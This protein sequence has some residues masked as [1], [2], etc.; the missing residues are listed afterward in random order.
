MDSATSHIAAINQPN[1]SAEPEP[2]LILQQ[3][4]SYATDD[5][6][7]LG[8]QISSEA[9]GSALEID[10]LPPGTTLSSG[11][12]VGQGGWRIVA[13]NVG[14]AM[15]HPPQGFRGALDFNVE[16]RLADDSVIDRGSF[17]LEWTPLVPPATVASASDTATSGIS[18]NNP[19]VSAAPSESNA[20][21]PTAE[22]RLD[23]WQIE[24]L[25]G[26]SQKLMTQGDFGAARTLLE[27]AAEARDARAALALGSTFD[28]IM[29]TILHA[30]G[31]APD[32]SLARYWYQ[33]ASE[34][35]SEEAE[36][37]LKLLAP[38]KADEVSQIAVGRVSLSLFAPGK[39]NKVV[40]E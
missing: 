29:L 16:L 33:K 1:G 14:N 17:R 7:P 37:R 4:T 13:A 2:H 31:I 39:T 34:L 22:S 25:I 26:Q 20:I 24:H 10:G 19:M 3:N 36:E 38:A 9:A 18:S 12:A 30:R 11:R 40:I 32:V 21:P 27:R 6:I 15:I 28:P 23:R 5:T 8:L 35:G